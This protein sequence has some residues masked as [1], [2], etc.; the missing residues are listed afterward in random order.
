MSNKEFVGFTHRSS[1]VVI[2][3]SAIDT[4]ITD[5]VV[6][7]FRYN[8]G[9]V[10]NIPDG[11]LDGST[12]SA[13]Q[14]L[15][16]IAV[17]IRSTDTSTG[18]FTRLPCHIS[19][20]VVDATEANRRAVIWVRFPSLSSTVNT[21]VFFF[22]GG[23]GN[24]E[25]IGGVYNKENTWQDVHNVYTMED[26]TSTTIVDHGSDGQNGTIVN[27]LTDVDTI[28]GSGQSFDHTMQQY[29]NMPDK[30]GEP[31]QYTMHVVFKKGSASG[32]RDIFGIADNQ[33]IYHSPTGQLI[34]AYRNN[35]GGTTAWL[36]FFGPTLTS[37]SWNI[38]TLKGQQGEQKAFHNG[39]QFGS[40]SSTS[41]DDAPS[42]DRGTESSIGR[43]PFLNSHH[44]DDDIAFVFFSHDYLSDSHIKAMHENQKENSTMISVSSQTM[45][46]NVLPTKI[47][48]V[49]R[50]PF[51]LNSVSLDIDISGLNLFDLDV[52]I[53]NM[54]YASLSNNARAYAV[55]YEVI[56][57]NTVR[58]SRATVI[59]DILGHLE[60][61]EFE[62]DA[63][64]RAFRGTLVVDGSGFGGSGT[65]P[66]AIPIPVNVDRTFMTTSHDSDASIL[67]GGFN[68]YNTYVYH[69]TGKDAGIQRTKIGSAANAINVSYQIITHHNIRVSDYPYLNDQAILDTTITAVN[70]RKA[71]CFATARP[72]IE[73]Y[74]ANASNLH[75]VYFTSDTNVRMESYDNSSATWTGSVFVIEFTDDTVIHQSTGEI[76][77]DSDI[78]VLIPNKNKTALMIGSDHANYLS[79]DSTG[80]PGDEMLGRMILDQADSFS[81]DRFGGSLNARYS[82]FLLSQI[83][84]TTQQN[85]TSGG[86]NRGLKGGFQ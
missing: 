21:E 9:G 71:I 52:C 15:K 10:K 83:D 76:N 40:N 72:T 2:Q 49:H 19:D 67:L 61:I 26:L 31:A 11:V 64:V 5:P 37:G 60:I 3:A 16:N 32:R 85:G 56:D 35:N 46:E 62:K 23:G 25:R 43:S 74:I 13:M 50:V 73:N 57:I 29:I 86:L 45:V 48:K 36:D 33:V 65:N 77:S 51:T 70:R 1:P 20:L 59:G 4:D 41:F 63:A 7:C 82:V 6:L 68:M 54:T 38:V 78:S 42:Y 66:I 17:G 30:L 28:L 69:S 27:G 84:K 55:K 81:L 8:Y 39:V 58:V 34:G 12:T 14:A 53:F 18:E 22:S 44:W 75:R 80:D 24:A 79:A 47:K